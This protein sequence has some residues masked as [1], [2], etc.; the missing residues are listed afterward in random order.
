MTWLHVRDL[1][2]PSENTPRVTQ[3]VGEVH[4]VRRQRIHLPTSGR[5]ASPAM[6]QTDPA[7]FLAD[8]L[9]RLAGTAP[10]GNATSHVV[11]EDSSEGLWK[12]Y[13]TR[14]ASWAHLIREI[15]SLDVPKCRRQGLQGRDSR[16]SLLQD[17]G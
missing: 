8:A 14:S 15:T 1:D 17:R 9:Y 13:S 4:A 2:T 12:E 11:G 7:R 3:D 6:F 5:K 10:N 16:D